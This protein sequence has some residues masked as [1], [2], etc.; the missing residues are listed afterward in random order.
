MG[1][2]FP[3]TKPC[4]RGGYGILYGAM[5]YADFGGFNRVR[6]SSEP[7]VFFSR[8]LQSRIQR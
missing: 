8:R 5:T 2:P 7:I 1:P 3:A 6:L 4:F